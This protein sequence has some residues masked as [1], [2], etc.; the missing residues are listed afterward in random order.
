MLI[1]YLRRQ[2]H[3]HEART[4]FSDLVYKNLDW[5]EAIWEGWIAFEHQYGSVEELETCL[6]KVEKAQA[7]VNLRRAKAS[8]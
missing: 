7:H 4:V 8:D 2:K 5:P 3:Y 6:D 1:F